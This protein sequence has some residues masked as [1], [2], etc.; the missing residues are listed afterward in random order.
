MRLNGREVLYA[1]KNCAEQ[2]R[3]NHRISIDIVFREIHGDSY[4]VCSKATDPT[5]RYDTSIGAVSIAGLKGD[6]LANAMMKAETKSKRRVTLSILGLGMLDETEVESIPHTQRPNN[7]IE[8]VTPQTSV[9]PKELPSSTTKITDLH[10]ELIKL[11]AQKGISRELQDEWCTRAKVKDIYSLDEKKVSS[12]I[13]QW[14]GK[15]D[16]KLDSEDMQ[17]INKMGGNNE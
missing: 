13:K 2:L 17:V 16:V 5:G 12:L 8:N 11:I 10:E 7:K 1:G 4:M 9:K 14:E 6:A 3:K 15:P